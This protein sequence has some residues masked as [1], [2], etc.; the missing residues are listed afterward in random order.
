MIRRVL[1]AIVVCMG[2]AQVQEGFGDDKPLANDAGVATQPT[3]PGP[4]PPKRVLP[5]SID[6]KRAGAAAL[7]QYDAN[8][9]GK[10]AGDEL[11]K[12]PSLKAAL[13]NLDLDKDKAVSAEEVTRRIEAWQATRLGRMALPLTVMY[14]GKPLE[15]AKVVFEPE[16]FLGSH[17]K[18]ALGATDSSGV[19][20]VT[21]DDKTGLPGVV[22]GLYRVKIT[23]RGVNIPSKYNKKTVL[24]VEVARDA[25]DVETGPVFDLK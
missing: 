1:F 23:K 8:R 4:L 24:G 5:P 14:R 10:V 7:R 17:V 20:M 6:A 3:S 18:Q 9:D 16:A 25:K 11:K 15:G 12:S 19:A 2:F 22:P 13:K 21:T